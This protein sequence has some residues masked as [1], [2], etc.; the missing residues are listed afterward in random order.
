MGREIDLKEC[1]WRV[2]KADAHN[3]VSIEHT[4]AL[5]AICGMA[6]ARIAEIET[7]LRNVDL[8]GGTPYW[9]IEDSEGFKDSDTLNVDLPVWV[10]RA[11]Q[12]AVKTASAKAD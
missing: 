9:R 5:V 11:I 7:A 10:L 1:L 3:E 6:R 2:T 12:K 4:Q 8:F